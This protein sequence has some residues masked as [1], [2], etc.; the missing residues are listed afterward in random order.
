M[1]LDGLPTFVH[2]G[3]KHLLVFFTEQFDGLAKC[4]G[5]C[6]HVQVGQLVFEVAIVEFIANSFGLNL[7]QIGQINVVG[8]V[9][10]H[11]LVDA[12]TS[13]IISGELD[14]CEV[15][16]PLHAAQRLGMCVQVFELRP[17]LCCSR[18]YFLSRLNFRGYQLC[19]DPSLEC[20][21]YSICGLRVRLG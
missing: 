12:G 2:S 14:I 13:V 10:V 5:L 4:R 16:E 19:Q 1:H 3:E 9:D 7:L 18:L 20:K 8:F 21:V 6:K 11:E 17:L 15:V